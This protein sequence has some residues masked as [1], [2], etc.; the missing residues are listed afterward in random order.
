MLHSPSYHAFLMHYV[1]KTQNKSDDIS[2]A[3]CL[4]TKPE[5]NCIK[6]NC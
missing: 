3:V 5:P 1:L 4:T 2:V 6:W